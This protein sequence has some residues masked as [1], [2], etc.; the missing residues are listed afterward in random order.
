MNI[1]RIIPLALILSALSFTSQIPATQQTVEWR[2]DQ[3]QPDWKA[4]PFGPPPYS[5]AALARTTGGLRVSLTERNRVGAALRGAIHVNVPDWSAGDW[6][7][8]IVRARA[9]STSTVSLIGLAFNVRDGRGSASDPV[10]APFLL[11]AGQP[12]PVVRDGTVRTYR[13]RVDAAALNSRGPLRQ[14]GI[15]LGTDGKPGSIEI[16]S[17]SAMRTGA[18]H[19]HSRDMLR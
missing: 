9:D 14:L 7:E 18:D 12:T 6:A 16:L 5:T 4:T 13:L 2:F 17:V 15:M 10:Q 3:P 19:T 8:V 1:P 11:F